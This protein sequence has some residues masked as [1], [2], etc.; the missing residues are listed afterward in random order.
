MTF[1]SVQAEVSEKHAAVMLSAYGF[2]SFFGV[3]THARTREASV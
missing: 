2:G 3:T 1:C